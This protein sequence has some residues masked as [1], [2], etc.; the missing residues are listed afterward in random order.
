MYRAKN[1]FLIVAL[2]LVSTQF[3]SADNKQVIAEIGNYKLSVEELERAFKKNMNRSAESIYDLPADSLRQ[4]LNLFVNYKLKVQDALNKGLDK[5]SSVMAD[6][7][8][9]RKLLAESFFFERKIVRP[10]IERYVRLRE[11]EAKIAYIIINQGSV[12]S[13]TKEDA[14]QY[15]GEILSEILNGEDFHKMAMKVT[16]DSAAG[17][18]GGIVDQYVLAGRV[19]RVMEDAIFSLKPGEIYPSVIE[20]NY[21]YFLVKLV[22]LADRVLVRPAHILVSSNNKDEE[23]EALKKAEAIYQRLVKGEDFGALAE[24]LSD[25]PSSAMRGGEFEDL[26]SRSGGFV[27]SGQQMLP[28]FVAGLFDLKDGQFS[29]PVKTDYGFHIIKRLET[30]PYNKEEDLKDI[31]ATY[32]RFYYE[33]DKRAFMDSVSLA[34]GLNINKVVFNEMISYLDTMKTNINRVW[35]DSIPEKVMKKELFSYGKK[36]YSVKDFIKLLNSEREFAGTALNFEGLNK[37]IFK[38]VESDVFTDLTANLETEYSEFALLINEFK[39]GI[40][41]FKVENDEV[42]DKVRKFDSTLARAYWDTT[43]TRYYTEILYDISEIYVTS[44]TTAFRL[45]E[46]AQAGADFAKLAA[47]NTQRDGFREKSGYW[48]EIIPKRSKFA[49]ILL[50][51]K[52]TAGEILEPKRSDFGLSILKIN[53]VLPP[54]QKTFE[55]AISDFASNY[56]EQRQS[57]ITNKWLDKIRKENKVIINEKVLNEVASKK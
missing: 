22:D 26:Y 37:S 30:K 18:K 8:S 12:E 1:L 38:S 9:N 19:Q 29:K 32:K 46:E 53:R 17:A 15:A 36:K 13:K 10:N 24:E 23:A 51:R 11:K 7:K 43:K 34:R 47:E 48:G 16:A 3:S 50:D 45:Y 20:T 33:Q 28:E 27:K 56:Q 41:L 2:F 21:G 4:F 49:N 14:K 42:W 40:L 39:D 25:D 6:I 35:G 52:F 57:N 55:E 54:R 44:D 5:D 31:T